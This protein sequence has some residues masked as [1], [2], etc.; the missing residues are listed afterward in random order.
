[1]K[2]FLLVSLVAAIAAT[3]GSV[4]L[5]G[6]AIAAGSGSPVAVSS[7]GIKCKGGTPGDTA[8]GEECGPKVSA[9]DMRKAVA[10][11]VPATLAPAQSDPGATYGPESLYQIGP[12]GRGLAL[13]RGEDGG[14]KVSTTRTVCREAPGGG[15]QCVTAYDCDRFVLWLQKGKIP[16]QTPDGPAFPGSFT[17]MTTVPFKKP[18]KL[19]VYNFSDHEPLP[20][21]AV[22]V[23]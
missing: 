6:S 14:C 21:C 13:H 3:F 9:T 16:G 18:W 10:A 12:C 8:K 7:G 4:V 1:M 5:V 2:R 20:E 19:R 23:F 15:T 17:V 22:P 11:A